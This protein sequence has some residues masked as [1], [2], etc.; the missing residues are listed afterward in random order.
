MEEEGNNIFNEEQAQ[1]ENI[2]VTNEEQQNINIT[3]I[4]LLM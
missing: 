3:N 2:Q 1:E 4:D